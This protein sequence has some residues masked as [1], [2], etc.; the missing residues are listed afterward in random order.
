MSP[1]HTHSYTETLAIRY[2]SMKI[3]IFI[4]LYV[5]YT[6][7]IA[8]KIEAIYKP[9]TL[10]DLG[11]KIDR[12]DVRNSKDGNFLSHISLNNVRGH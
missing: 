1:I 7:T 2:P 5:V 6:H 8:F 11:I 3:L 12:F 4:V 10:N 9:P